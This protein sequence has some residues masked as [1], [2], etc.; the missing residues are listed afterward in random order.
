M[1]TARLLARAR[2][3]AGVLAQPRIEQVWLADPSPAPER[4]AEFGMLLLDNGAAGLYY[5]WLGGEQ[6]ELARRIAPATLAG[7]PAAEVAERFAAASDI[8][9]S[10]GIAAINALTA[11]LYQ[12]AGYHPPAA[13]DA[14]GGINLQPGDHLGMIGNFPPLVRRARSLHVPVTVVEQKQHMLRDE[15]GLTITLDPDTL[16]HCNKIL[17]TGATLLNNSLETMLGYC[18]HA[19]VVALVGP[20]VGCFPDDLFALGIDAVAGTAVSDGAA[21]CASLA[22]DAGFGG[23]TRKTLI[24]RESYPGFAELIGLAGNR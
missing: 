15:P 12:R 22:A 10:L 24:T 7:Q 21:A 14:F 23:Y 8:E 3:A 9:R 2:E 18:R 16:R 19:E 20:T 13:E 6:A 17:C 11:S 4:D 5:A 1:L